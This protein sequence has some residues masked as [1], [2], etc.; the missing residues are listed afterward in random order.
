[1]ILKKLDEAVRG[2]RDEYSVPQHA[3]VVFG[4]VPAEDH[5][6]SCF[7][8]GSVLSVFGDPV[9]DMTP[10]QNYQRKC[11]LRFPYCD[12][13]A[14]TIQQG[15][16]NFQS[17]RL[18]FLV[19]QRKKGRKFKLS[20]LINYIS[21]LRTIAA[22][23]ALKKVSVFDL[24][25]IKA[26]ALEYV[27]AYPAQSTRFYVFLNL[28][29]VAGSEK[30]GFTVM[31][32]RDVKII[33]QSVK[34]A[35]R[36][37]G[38]HPPITLRVL[39]LLI[40]QLTVFL[41]DYEA[42][43]DAYLSV[44]RLC[45][46][47]T[48][49]GRSESSQEK[50]RLSG[51]SLPGAVGEPLKSI[52]TRYGL[53]GFFKKYRLPENMKGLAKGLIK[54]RSAGKCL[55]HV[56]SGMRD[57]EGLSLPLYCTKTEIAAG[58]SHCLIVGETTKFAPEGTQ[59]VRWV[60]SPEGHWAIRRVQKISELIYAYNYGED[61]RDRLGDAQ[62]FLFVGPS[63]LPLFGGAKPEGEQLI[64]TKFKSDIQDIE[65]FIP[66][67]QEEDLREL[68]RIDTMRAW[69]S[70]DSFKVGEMW[71][72]TSHQLRRSLA[73]YARRS[74]LVSL[75]SLKR[76]LKHL[77][78]SMSLYYANGSA[79]AT[80]FIGQNNDHFGNYWRSEQALH[81]ALSYEFEVLEKLGDLIGPHALWAENAHI[82]SEGRL[83]VNRE[84]TIKRFQ[85]GEIAFKETPLGG[86]VSL[87]VCEHSSVQFFSSECVKG[88]VNFVGNRTKM[89]VIAIAQSR[90]V[91]KLEP[92]SIEHRTEKRE[93]EAIQAALI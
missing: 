58:K 38:Q 34:L 11:E 25:S 87:D 50:S 16:A 59:H 88:C 8:D 7:A 2:G 49:T 18:L 52:L 40:Q 70:E 19:I 28:T 90:F 54:V 46:Q 73:L 5:P 24:I 3:P 80:N 14:P 81:D 10:Y 62:T 45:S 35:R 86:C 55:T 51:K 89:K 6:I 33:A 32:E 72:L 56:Y 82:D 9:W 91:E 31:S 23:A 30:M 26:R 13:E 92:G 78:E 43:E 15:V 83:L 4:A 47:D 36:P 67:I 57:T 74:G 68:E 39:S 27:A 65:E 60:T 64:F 21:T 75:P 63:Y 85:N 20:T 71:P 76:Q 22:F 41:T 12:E 17:R 93:L 53:T 29:R 48:I 44:V 37:D 69:R 66:L 79:F 61:F 42:V 77:A 1:M 84:D